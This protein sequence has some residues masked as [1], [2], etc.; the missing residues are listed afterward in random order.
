MRASIRDL[1]LEGSRTGR[2]FYALKPASWPKLVV[3]ALF[4]QLLGAAEHGSL[5]LA[6]L[7]WGFAFTGF[8]LAY[9]VLLNDWG[10]R[11]V[12]AIKRRMFPDG[13]SPK[14]IPDGILNG[15]SVAAA[16]AFCGAAT[17][18]L[19]AGAESA[20]GRPFAFE[21]GL[22]CMLLFVAYTLPPARLNYRG[23]GELLE[24]FGVGIALPVFNLYIQAGTIPWHVWPWIAGFAC[25]SLASAV[26]SGLSDEQSDRAGGKRTFAS[27]FGN[28]AARRLT[29]GS[30]LLGAG[31]W[32]G[33]MW[34]RPEWMPV[35]A[36]GA[37]LLVL[38][39]NFI[40]LRRVSSQAVTNAFRAQGAYKG[41]LHRAIWHSTTVASLLVWLHSTLS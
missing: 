15:R 41:F 4:G 11:E 12:D 9:I 25:L 17:L 14:T 37:A 2:W 24:M 3:P 27:T 5:D 28:R 39:W 40:G 22:G 19:A 18:V 32:G 23:G 7:G 1:R 20:L 30:V 16:G 38:A 8:G 29:E 36:V 13:C 31:I 10:D 33:A 34:F 26:A 6:A 35:W 21:M